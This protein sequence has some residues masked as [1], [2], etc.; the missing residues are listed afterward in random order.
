MAMGA[1]IYPSNGWPAIEITEGLRIPSFCADMSV[2]VNTTQAVPNFIPGSQLIAVPRSTFTITPPFGTSPLPNFSGVGGIIVDSVNGTVSAQQVNYGGSDAVAGVSVFQVLPAIPQTYGLTLINST[3][4]INISSVGTYC[5]AFYRTAF[6][7]V[8]TWN[9]PEVAGYPNVNNYI[10]FA[11]WDNP[12]VTIERNFNGQIVCKAL[13]GTQ[14]VDAA[15]NIQLIYFYPNR[16]P[17]YTPGDYGLAVFNQ[18]GQCT[19]SSSHSPMMIKGFVATSDAWSGI[20]FSY[21]CSRPAVC[22]GNSFG[23]DWT[24][25]GFN[26]YFN[27]GLMMSG[28][29]VRLGRGSKAWQFNYANNRYNWATTASVILPVIDAANYF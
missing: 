10:I 28:G 20:S 16:A 9:I 15:T 11:W 21:P 7:L 17:I 14:V 29:S 5:Q 22:L 23:C 3:D 27:K 19:F 2:Q 13:D 25:D 1:I 26:N 18:Y 12:N 4:L 6:T 24:Y 8:G